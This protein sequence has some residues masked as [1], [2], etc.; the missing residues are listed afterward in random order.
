MKDN[1]P[2]AMPTS[3][4]T[5][6]QTSQRIKSGE[7]TSSDLVSEFLMKAEKYAAYNTITSIAEDIRT[8]ASE[9]D[10]KLK[11]A[12]QP[13]FEQKLETNQR[14][15]SVQQLAGIPILVKDNICV[16]NLVTSAGSRMLENFVSPYDATVIKR[17]REAGLII[18]GHTN[19]DEFGM[20]STSE[21]SVY[22]AVHNPWDFER[23][24]GGSSGGSAAAVALGIVPF[25]LGS[26]T[27]GSVRQPAAFCG[28]YG[29]KP[30][31]GS[32]SRYG[33]IAYASSMDQIG[34]IAADIS[35]LKALYD[36]IVEPEQVVAAQHYLMSKKFPVKAALLKIKGMN[37]YYDILMDRSSGVIGE[38]QEVEIENLRFAVPAYYIIACAEASSNLARYDGIRYGYESVDKA[39]SDSNQEINSLE[40]LY[41]RTRTEGLGS[42][43]KRRIMLGN[44]VLSRGFYEAYY[45]KATRVRE[46]LTHEIN[47]ILEDNEI[48]V[49]PI[50]SVSAPYLGKSLD[51]PL[52]MY[53]SDE[54]TVLA[55][56]TGHPS[57]AIPCGTYEDGM[58]FGLQLIG[59]AGSEALLLKV[60]ESYQN[61]L[62][63][64]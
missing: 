5:A 1:N 62:R 26:D 61:S 59:K 30:T 63:Q 16:K 23:S 25:A 50:S 60:A 12:Q 11:S 21:T 6:I 15:G 13:E 34:P 40:E 4:E 35:D 10:D 37:S 38:T 20:G 48:L 56:L 53:Q 42:E 54:Y 58:P 28:V 47:R 49:M 7:L 22:G 43:V 2:H 3:R 64:V 19:M 41:I 39:K 17:L 9:A 32:V 31:Y 27:G 44:F 51:N 46:V 29:L 36:I 24:A 8:Q 52:R 14:K 45:T 57:L 55:N 18:A 33:L